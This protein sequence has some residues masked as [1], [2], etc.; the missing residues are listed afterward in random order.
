MKS[1]LESRQVGNQ[2]SDSFNWYA[3]HTNSRQ[4]ERANNNLRAWGV[5]TFNP[6]LRKRSYNPYTGTPGY[7]VKPMF[8]RY[9]FAEFQ[10]NKFLHKVRYTRGV[11]SVVS[12]GD[13]PTRIDRDIIDLMQMQVDDDGFIKIDDELKYGDRVII[14][15]G[16]ITNLIGIFQQ[17]SKG[18]D[19]VAILLSTISY[20]GC[21]IVNRSA[22][23]KMV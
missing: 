7:V 13:G 3:I 2:Q 16:L 22:V 12:F 19:R 10:A 18:R 4:E 23:R 14:N 21:I 5:N 11:H 20:Q 15:D 9:I 6:L 1:L 8:P 17:K